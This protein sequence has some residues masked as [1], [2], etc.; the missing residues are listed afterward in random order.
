MRAL[1]VFILFGLVAFSAGCGGGGGGTSLP[2]GTLAQSPDGKVAIEGSS[3]AVPTG[4]TLSVQSKLATQLVPSPSGAAFVAGALVS[5]AGTAFTQP[6][7]LKFTLSTPL[8]TGET[9]DLF[10]YT[11]GAWRQVGAVVTL[12]AD[13]GTLTVPVSALSA[14]GQYA[15]L[16]I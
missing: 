1:L 11:A 4:V 7:T 5:P 8:A 3:S 14:D 9:V 2:P 16:K 10:H 6:V 15:V 13:R 12:S